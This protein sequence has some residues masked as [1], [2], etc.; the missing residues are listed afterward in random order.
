M[1]DN[2]F[3]SIRDNMIQV[4]TDPRWAGVIETIKVSCSNPN[5]PEHKS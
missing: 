3:E 2:A 4:L 5:C 1:Q